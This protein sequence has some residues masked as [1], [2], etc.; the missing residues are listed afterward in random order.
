M[1]W[2]EENALNDLKVGDLVRYRNGNKEPRTFLVV[3]VSPER[4]CKVNTVQYVQVVRNDDGRR[5][6]F[7][8]KTLTTNLDCHLERQY[9]NR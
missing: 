5:L 2:W 4:T 6:S 8:S 7:A 3:S 9:E 1:K